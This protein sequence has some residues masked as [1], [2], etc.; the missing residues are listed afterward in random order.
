MSERYIFQFD[1][2]LAPDAPLAVL[3]SFEALARG[4][5]PAP[6]ALKSFRLGGFL[7]HAMMKE[8]RDQIGTSVAVWKTGIVDNPNNPHHAPSPTH[9]VRFAFVMHDD[10]FANGGFALPFAVFD[11]VGDH[12]HFGFEFDETNRTSLKLYF[13]EFDDHIVQE[14][15]APSMAYPLP[16]AA[17]RNPAGY[18]KGWKPATAEGFKCGTFT[19]YTSSERAAILAEADSIGEQ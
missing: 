16:P 4:E 1:F 17:A 10:H 12:G 15:V 13:K 2:G 14:I 7:D 5:K 3:E 9:G 19:R 8:Y 6:G 18:L 11:W